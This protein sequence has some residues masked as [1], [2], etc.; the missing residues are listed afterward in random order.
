VVDF[1]YWAFISYSH[2][3]DAVAG[4][5]HRNIERFRVPRRLIGR[6]SRDGTMPSRLAPV[7]RDREELPGASNLGEK[8]SD[9]IQRSRYLIVVCSPHA[10]VSHWVNEEIRLFKSLGREDRVLAVIVD[11]E[12]GA[13]AAKGKG[14]LE[15]F[16]EALRFHVEPDGTITDQPTEPIAADFRKGKDGRSRGLLKLLAGILDV[17][18]DELRQREQRRRFWLRVR[19]G[20]L[21]T[22][23]VASLAAVWYRGYQETRDAERRRHVQ[24][25]ELLLRKANDASRLGD[26]ATAAFYGANALREG[27]EGATPPGPRVADFLASLRL[28]AAFDRTIRGSSPLL[29]IAL[30]PDGARLAL[31]YEDGSLAVDDTATGRS[32]AGWAGGG[33]AVTALAYSPDGAALWVGLRDG[34]FRQ[35]DGA[36]PTATPGTGAAVVAIRCAGDLV[37]TAARDGG[38]RIFRASDGHLVSAF[39]HG[40]AINALA[41]DGT[42][43]VSAADDQAVRFWD[44]MTGQPA[45][46]PLQMEEPVRSLAFDGHGRLALGS[47]DTTIRLW[48]GTTGTVGP[49]LPGHRK[50]VDGITFAQGGRLLVSGSLDTTTMIWDAA[51]LEPIATLRGH[52]D[53]VIAVAVD[54]QGR[55]LVTAG[56]DGTANIWRLAPQRYEAALAGHKRAVRAVAYSPDGSLLASAADDRAILLREAADGRL[57]SRLEEGSH[58]D[59]VRAL[60]FKPDGS[61]LYSAGRDRQIIAW[62]PATGKAVRRVEDAHTHW[63]FALAMAPDGRH[64]ATAGY[65][66]VVKY[67]SLPDL[68]EVWSLA[69][70]GGKPVG[71]LAFSPDGRLLASAGDD[72]VVRVRTAADGAEV[73]A[74]P[75]FDDIARAV[76]FSPDGK[77]LAGAGADSLIRVWAMPDGRLVH[78]LLGHNALMVWTLAFSP[79]GRHLASG[80]Q[81]MD[82]QTLRLW[83]TTTWSLA[84]RLP[85]HKDFALTVAFSPDGKHL[86]SG[87]TDGTV[88]LWPVAADAEPGLLEHP[89]LSS[90]AAEELAAEVG[91]STALNLVGSDAV[92]TAGMEPAETALKGRFDR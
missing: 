61:R 85:G 46:S 22:L 20:V 89:R 47:W 3:D 45:G 21:A 32:L 41:F 78:T 75:P 6:P 36:G 40:A 5:V 80:S 10:A 63:I 42:I 88:R 55:R 44:P 29:S 51:S 87:G 13:S 18:F 48:D 1:K 54:R 81:S 4:W 30:S 65:D 62:D 84:A 7:F 14:L 59:A 91:R 68:T 34:R 79:D 86:A 73:F 43:L 82:R 39:N 64:L 72:R 92:P 69:P 90:E 8:I 71:G 57:V 66:G 50:S 26:D 60:A 19:L 76:A 2:Q 12:P 56:K 28:E 35:L 11:G 23:V 24:M 52:R 37:A 83:D 16:P 9:A 33:S 27:I 53:S 77:L 58:A 25:A 15:C 38:I 31:G 70:H 17:G 74:A 67:W 49:P